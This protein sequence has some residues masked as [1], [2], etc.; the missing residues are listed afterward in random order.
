MKKWILILCAMLSFNAKAA[1]D[2]ADGEQNCWDCGKTA[3]DLCT[4]RRIGEQLQI[5]GSGEMRDYEFYR[6]LAYNSEESSEPINSPHG[7]YNGPWGF[8]ETNV[9]WGYDYTSV[10]VEGVKNIGEYAFDYASVKTAEISDTVTSLGASAFDSCYS[11]KDVRLSNALTSIGD[12]AFG[13]AAHPDF[14][15]ENLPMINLVIPSS[16]GSIGENAFFQTYT[17]SLVIEGTPDIADNAFSYL[18]KV[19]GKE[20]NVKIYCLDASVC[21]NKGQGE[22]VSVVEYTKNPDTGLYQTS[23]GKL[24]ATADLMVYGAACA[25]EAQCKD[26]LAAANTGQPFRVGSKFYRSLEDFAKGNRINKRIYSVEEATA[27]S[28]P[29]GNTFKLRYK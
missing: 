2:C 19:G 3:S 28:K 1:S 27:V 22:A 4:A 26:I 18:G 9:P 6:D 5:T 24:F 29:T 16:V 15:D 10:S 13:W 20:L 23:D 14:G 25:D 17:N 11:L 12:Y 8:G 7:P 21:E